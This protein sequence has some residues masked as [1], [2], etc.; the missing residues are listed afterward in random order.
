MTD[1]YDAAGMVGGAALNTPAH[2][3]GQTKGLAFHHPLAWARLRR[4]AKQRPVFSGKIICSEQGAPA[5]T[6]SDAFSE[7]Y[8][9]LL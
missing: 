9:E 7:Y 2:L 1:G 3:L 4:T 5:M 8:A 6:A